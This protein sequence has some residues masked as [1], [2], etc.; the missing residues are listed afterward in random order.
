MP[1]IP[2]SHAAAQNIPSHN[3]K[4]AIV[5]NSTER[6]KPSISIQKKQLGMKH[7]ISRKVSC[8]KPF[9]DTTKKALGIQYQIFIDVIIYHLV[10]VERFYCRTL[11]FFSDQQLLLFLIKQLPSY[12]TLKPSGLDK[13]GPNPALEIIR[14]PRLDNPIYFMPLTKEHC[15]YGLTRWSLNF[16][17]PLAHIKGFLTHSS[18][19]PALRVYHSK[20]WG[21]A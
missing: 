16:I 20:V 5:H 9:K 21:V 4:Y 3:R 7:T 15:L 14:L 8:P 13:A 19:G 18:L 2:C 1:C 6:V 12:S 17:I 10:L 11:V